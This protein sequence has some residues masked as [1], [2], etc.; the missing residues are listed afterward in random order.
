MNILRSILDIIETESVMDDKSD[1]IVMVNG[2]KNHITT[3]T[4]ALATERRRPKNGYG[5]GL[6]YKRAS[7]EPQTSLALWLLHMLSCFLLVLPYVLE[8]KSG[9]LLFI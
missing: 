9:K 1:L 4:M 2:S 3:R 6:G 7:Q 8:R 5:S